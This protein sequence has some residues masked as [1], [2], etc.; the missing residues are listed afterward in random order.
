MTLIVLTA[1]Y[2]YHT[3]AVSENSSDMAYVH[4][5]FQLLLYECD[6]SCLFANSA[7]YPVRWNNHF[8][9]TL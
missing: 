2:G 9:F 4:S 5:M 3:Q 8:L 1:I 7:P 6:K